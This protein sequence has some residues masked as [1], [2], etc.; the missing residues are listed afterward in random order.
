MGDVS[1][2]RNT[3]YK[4]DRWRT[5][6]DKEKEAKREIGGGREWTKKYKL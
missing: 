5:L 1:G 4:R 6:V 3:S 2:Q